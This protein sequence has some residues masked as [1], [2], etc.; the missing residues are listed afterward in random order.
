MD[1]NNTHHYDYSGLL[2]LSDHG[3][4]TPPLLIALTPVALILTHQHRRHPGIR[5]R[6]VRVHRWTEYRAALALPGR[7]L[8]GEPYPLGVS[9]TPWV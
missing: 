8:K 1:K 5:G 7:G 2:Y 3:E 6:D 9:F 4:V